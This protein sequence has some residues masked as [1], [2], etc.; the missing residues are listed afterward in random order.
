M[1]LLLMPTY[2]LVSVAL[3]FFSYEINSEGRTSGS[4]RTHQRKENRRLRFI[5]CVMSSNVML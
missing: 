2:A 3:N 1:N 5:K 4:K